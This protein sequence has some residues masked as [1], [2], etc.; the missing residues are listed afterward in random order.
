MLKR[1]TKHSKKM[2]EGKFNLKKKKEIKIITKQMKS[3]LSK[4]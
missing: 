1:S 2:E 4:T 3:Y